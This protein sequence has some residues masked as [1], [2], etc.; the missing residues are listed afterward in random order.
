VERILGR[1]DALL[2]HSKAAGH[3]RATLDIDPHTVR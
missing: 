2:Y 3:N 1:A